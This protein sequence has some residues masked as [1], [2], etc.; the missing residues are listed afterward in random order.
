M[1]TAAVTIHSALI[2][3][4]RW[5]AM[6]AV[7]IAPASASTAA[8]ILLINSLAPAPLR[9]ALRPQRVQRP[10][11]AR[12]ERIAI[13]MTPAAHHPLACPPHAIDE[14][15]PTG[16]DPAVEKLIAV[17]LE[18]HR[19]IRRERHHIERGAADEAPRV[20][21]HVGV[22]C[23]PAAGER[24]LEKGAARRDVGTRREHVA[25]PLCETLRVLERA[26]LRGSVQLNVGIA[27]DAEA[28]TASAQVCGR[29]DAIAET[30]LG[31]G[32]EP[33]HGAAGG[34]AIELAGSGMRRV[35]Q[36]PARSDRLGIDEPLDRPPSA[37][38]YT[39]IYLAH[40]F[41]DVNVNYTGAAELHQR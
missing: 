25:G 29:K 2:G 40:L 30:R 16:E 18:Q 28:A 1:H 14:L 4:C 38:R 22:Q 15:A 26:Q 33:H 23:L 32:A 36:A 3:S 6:P 7:A 35:H 37:P 9:H 10:P 20:H 41:R 21:R 8:E 19:M 39:L 13:P 27:A 11:I 5:S 31:D 17:A 34:D 12:D 24:L